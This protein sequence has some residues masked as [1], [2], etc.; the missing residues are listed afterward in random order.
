MVFSSTVF[1]FLFLPIV[2]LGYYLIGKSLRNPFL[3]F[4]SLFFYAWGE[5]LLVLLMLSSIVFNYFIGL[6]I[7]KKRFKDIQTG[8]GEAFLWLTS[9]VLINLASLIY[10]KYAL[11]IRESIMAVGIPVIDIGNIELP[12]GISFFTFQSLSYLIDVYKGEVRAQRNLLDLGTYIALFPQLIAGPIIRYHDIAKQLKRRSVTGASFL[13]GMNRFILG[14]ARK[15]LIANNAGFLA[16]Q[17]FNLPHEQ[18]STPI[19][20]LGVLCYALQIYYDFAGYS[21]MAIGLGKMFGFDFLENFNFPYISKSI[22]EFW[23]RWHISLSSWFRDY[24]YIPLGGNRNGTFLTYLNLGFVFFVTGLWHGASWNFVIWGLFHGFFMVVERLVKVKPFFLSTFLSHVYVLLVV[25][26][27]WVF[28]RVETLSGA[29]SFLKRMFVYWGD[30]S[31]RPLLF[32]DPFMISMLAIGMFFS[33]PNGV[34]MI[35]KL[36]SLLNLSNQQQQILSYSGTLILLLFS[37]MQLA[38]AT[39]NPFIYFRF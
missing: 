11:F 35:K 7:E 30:G 2:L 25:C 8:K 39:Y 33:I 1:L 21:D 15:L 34:R 9:G 31:M 20:W 24:L 23:R 13:E 6:Q 17:V 12:I 28:F 27:A 36:F 26:V 5:G 16:D 14:L 3:L 37:M 38:R 4:A 32:L 19:S 18:L 29:F 10:F 22:R